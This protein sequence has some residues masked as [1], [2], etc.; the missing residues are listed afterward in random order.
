MQLSAYIATFSAVLLPALLYMYLSVRERANI[1]DIRDFFPLKR[2]I[3]SGE[4]RSTT[5]AAGMSLATVIIAFINLAP[6]MGITLFVAVISYSLSFLILYPLVGRIMV[7]NPLNDS[8]QA[9]LGKRS[10]VFTGK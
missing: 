2:R 7:A 3:T 8:I 6:M 10:P 4:Y 9:F 1:K 5:V